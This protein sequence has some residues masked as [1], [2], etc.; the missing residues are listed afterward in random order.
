[1]ALHPALRQFVADGRRHYDQ[2]SWLLAP[3]SRYDAL[4]AAI[5]DPADVERW[6]DPITD[7]P[8]LLLIHADGA[9][10][11]IQE[12]LLIAPAD[13]Q[14]GLTG[15]IDPATLA[16]DPFQ[17]FGD[18]LTLSVS[19]SANAA[20]DALYPVI[21]RLFSRFVRNDRPLRHYDATFMLPLD[22]RLDSELANRDAVVTAGLQVR[23]D[24]IERYRVRSDDALLVARDQG[25]RDRDDELYHQ[26][27]EFF[28]THL[29]DQMFEREAGADDAA[30][31]AP[32]SQPLQPIRHW[33]LRPDHI[34]DWRID[35]LPYSPKGE[36]GEDNSA[37]SA[38]IR[39]VSLYQYYNQLLVLALR[40]QAPPLDAPISAWLDDDEGWWQALVFSDAAGFAQVE[41]RALNRWLHFSRHARIL[42]ADFREQ[43]DEGKVSLI[44]LRT[45]NGTPASMEPYSRFSEVIL[46][47]LR[48]FLPDLPAT[49]LR[50]SRR[51][52]QVDDSRQ[53][54]NAAYALAGPP[55]APGSAEMA[56]YERLFSWALYV[57]EARD[58]WMPGGW[59][60]DA[61]YT[62]ELMQTQVLR[63]WA[64]NGGLSGYTDYSSVAMGFGRFFSD[65]IAVAHVP[66]I[67]ARLQLAALFYRRSLDLFD[68][69]I[70]AATNELIDKRTQSRLFRE[71]RGDFIEFT[72]N[73]WFRQLSPQV[74][75]REVCERMMAAQGLDAK[76]A[77]VKDQMERA[78]DYADAL[79]A[80]WFQRRGEMVG[81]VASV[82]ALSALLLPLLGKDG[83]AFSPWQQLG[84]VAVFVLLAV[85]IARIYH[86]LSRNETRA[87]SSL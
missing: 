86:R 37:I 70:T 81:W 4:D 25:R 24:P 56:D 38:P 30:L 80:H 10:Q 45:A 72:N 2:L 20:D 76:Y 64:G 33:R 58:A 77:A 12:L 18:G 85:L 57:D 29:R 66:V 44:R 73:Y 5:G 22:L 83:F 50:R 67:Y 17:V 47:L 1:M 3:R 42:Y 34:R 6:S 15:D 31:P 63:R 9:P 65:V 59:C 51:L 21:S 16:R 14:P 68:R 40:V 26:A 39:D 55:P 13:E 46:Y 71:L 87:H 52:H 53:F 7:G 8:L 84:F 11:R 32:R 74:Q 19:A 41:A 69:R 61:D 27:Y 82:L 36:A 60:Y 62:R 23:G 49:D 79:R 43:L 48:G 54:I 28:A 35:L 75:G 78:D